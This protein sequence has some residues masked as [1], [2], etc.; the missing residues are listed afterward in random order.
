MRTTPSAQTSEVVD[1]QAVLARDPA[2]ATAKGKT[3]H[4][5]RRVD[6][7]RQGK[8]VKLRLLIDVGKETPRLYPGG[9]LVGI[10]MDPAHL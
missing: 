5:R 3:G 2:E 8:T 4:A 10:N 6:A 7:E 9:C 1:G